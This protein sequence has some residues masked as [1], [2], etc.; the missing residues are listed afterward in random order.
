LQD[1]PNGP[2]ELSYIT[3][4][5]SNLGLIPPPAIITDLIESAREDLSSEFEKNLEYRDRIRALLTGP[6][7]LSQNQR[8]NIEETDVLVSKNLSLINE[9]AVVCYTTLGRCVEKVSENRTALKVIDE[10]KL[11]VFPESL[12]QW[13]DIKDLASTK[14]SIQILLNELEKIAREKVVKF[15]ATEDKATVVEKTILEIR[16]L[17]FYKKNIT[18]IAPLSSLKNLEELFI[19]HGDS[20]IAITDIAPLSSL[21]NLRKLS[22]IQDKDIA[23]ISPLSSLVELRDLFIPC[24]MADIAQLKPLTKLERF[25]YGGSDTGLEPLS[26]FISLKV[27]GLDDIGGIVDISPLASLINLEALFLHENSIVDLNPL[28]SLTKLRTLLLHSNK[29]VDVSP[30]ASLTNLEVLSLDNNQIAD[31]NSLASLTNLKLL[32]LK[33]NPIVSQVCPVPDPT[34]EICKFSDV[35]ES[36][37]ESDSFITIQALVDEEDSNYLLYPNPFSKQS[38]YKV[39]KELVKVEKNTST[40]YL[41][42]EIIS[43]STVKI[44]KDSS[45]IKEERFSFESIASESLQSPERNSIEKVNGVIRNESSRNVWV[46][47]TTTGSAIAHIL[48]PRKSSPTTIDADGV[49]AYDLGVTLSGHTSWWKIYDPDTA[50]I[51]D[52]PNGQQ[53]IFSFAGFKVEEDE[54]GRRVTYDYTEGWGV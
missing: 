22:I 9:A 33:D 50:I 53:K 49:K 51:G 2:A 18:N 41:N 42:G 7:R 17:N 36:V 6:I 35:T 14:K 30:L 45:L 54:F 20:G 13:Y 26:H 12:A 39:Q 16:E 46:V 28:I 29:I 52:L 24:R 3:S 21:K 43:L 25:I 8:T 15:D 40:A 5:W 23:D 4:P 11:E 10:S 27:L 38:M 1:N 48:A 31:V 47:E 19:Y 37:V 32:S 44:N 34:G